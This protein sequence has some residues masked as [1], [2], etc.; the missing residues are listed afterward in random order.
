MAQYEEINID[1][2]SDVTIEL[3]LTNPDGSSKDLT[4]HSVT[5]W[6]K[7]N[8]MDD[9]AEAVKFSAQVLTPPSSGK[10]ALRL[11]NQQ[12]DL[13][14]YRRKYFYDVELSRLDSDSNTVIERILEGIASITPSVT[15]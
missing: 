7:Q 9:S 14:D 6:M 2:G 1:Q 13:L 15:K 5:A 3:R 12:T 10:I 11:T 4:D 8:Y